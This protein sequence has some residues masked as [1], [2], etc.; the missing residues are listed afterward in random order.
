MHKMLLINSLLAKQQISKFHLS[1]IW[2]HMSDRSIFHIGTGI[3]NALINVR[4]ALDWNPKD[5]GLELCLERLSCI[6][7][8]SEI[9]I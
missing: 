7:I 2:C 4:K 1:E 5:S 8:I 9:Y 3:T 6:I